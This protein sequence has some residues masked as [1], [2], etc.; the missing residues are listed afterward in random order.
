MEKNLKEI[1]ES[2]R[3]FKEQGEVASYIPA[4]SKVDK[5]L[6]GVSLI[7]IEGNIYNYG[8]YNKKFTIQ[9]ISKIIGLMI[10]VLE[11]GEE[12]IFE[13]V[14]YY[15]TDAPFN[16]Y[17]NLEKGI[18][19]LNP[20]MNAGAILITSL[21]EGEGFIPYEKIR[22]LIK[23]ITNN[24]DISF[25]EEAYISERETG[26]R[27]RGIFYLLKNNGL[28][29]KEEISLDNYFK[30]CCIEITSFDLAK[31][32]LF[33]ANNCTRYD[34]DKKYFNKNISILI[35]STM[36]N[37]GMYD[38]SGK[39]SRTVGIPSKSGVGG[40]IVSAVPGNMGIGIFSPPLDTHG[41]SIV[42]YNILK[43]LSKELNLSIF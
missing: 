42:G 38:Y 41:N 5:N 37:S 43:E 20:Y 19:P 10:A 16:S 2:N 29:N 9:S 36:M 31:I 35:N 18:K 14:G 21:I 7:D 3:H 23:Y 32:G 15:G 24:E 28:I 27:N 34:G 33:F 8:D 26:D 39:F 30:Q 11:K 25:N 6:L 40:G 4:L 13:R 22:D 12:Y 17:Y 1:V